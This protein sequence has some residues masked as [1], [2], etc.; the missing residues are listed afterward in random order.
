MRA[1]YYLVIRL[2]N[3]EW[4]PIRDCS[5][6]KRNVVL[7][8]GSRGGMIS[9]ILRVRKTTW[10]LTEGAHVQVRLKPDLDLIRIEKRGNL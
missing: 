4:K 10:T 3:I 8:S 2:E 1:A 7:L 6:S 5:E 9:E